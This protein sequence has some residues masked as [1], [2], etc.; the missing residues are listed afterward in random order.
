MVEGPVEKVGWAVFNAL[1]SVIPAG[2]KQFFYYSVFA[3][4][5]EIPVTV[6]T[7]FSPR[8]RRFLIYFLISLFFTLVMTCLVAFA[9][10]TLLPDPHSDPKR[11]SFLEDTWNL[12]LYAL[13]CPGYVAVC[14][15]IIG[16]SISYWDKTLPGPGAPEHLASV[17]NWRLLLSLALCLLAASVLIV[18]YIFDSVFNGLDELYWFL[19]APHV[20]NKAGFYY[21][22]LNYS[23]LLITAVS[24]LAYL[25]TVVSALSEI[26]QLSV[27]D[28]SEPSRVALRANIDHV[29]DFWEIM[30]LARILAA[31]YII[32]TYIWN[33]SPLGRATASNFWIAVF[34]I[35]LVGVIGTVLPKTLANRKF[36][37]LR[38]KI[39]A[40]KIDP[41]EMTRV[42]SG[43]N[44]WGRAA[45]IVVVA[46]FPLSM[47][48]LDYGFVE[49][50]EV[51]FK[52]GS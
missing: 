3:V 2:A 48:G 11:L 20:I 12:A 29:N 39:L 46:G 15:L 40:L 30:T 32:N 34:A 35:T 45:D 49:L 7:V 31:L 28:D 47:L 38:G 42:P 13:I 22:I 25:G 5:A 50:L 10:G 21:V 37:Q 36:K 44:F 19:H 4:S 27:E 41:D 23:L 16:A 51:L 9:S 26:S 8:R 24:I 33:Y 17:R 52:R 1:G 14:I 43:V 18:N 6:W